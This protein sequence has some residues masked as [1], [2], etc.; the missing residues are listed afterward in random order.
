[1]SLVMMLLTFFKPQKRIIA[2]LDS[3]KNNISFNERNVFLPLVSGMMSYFI[4][5]FTFIDNMEVDKMNYKKEDVP[6]AE[7]I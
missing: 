1:M 7:H 6:H 2:A 3:K 4:V 5:R